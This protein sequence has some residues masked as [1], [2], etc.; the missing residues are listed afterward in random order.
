MVTG[1]LPPGLESVD[2]RVHG[3][4]SLDIKNLAWLNL[5]INQDFVRFKPCFW[6][7]DKQ[8]ILLRADNTAVD[9]KLVL[10]HSVDYHV[11]YS[12]LTPGARFSNFISICRTWGS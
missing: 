4:L 8:Q 9:E 1:V 5:K 7:D 2:Q 11:R 10:K 3:K 6:G 12:R